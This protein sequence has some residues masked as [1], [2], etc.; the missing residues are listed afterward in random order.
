MAS[1]NPRSTATTSLATCCPRRMP[2]ATPPGSNTIPWGIAPNGFCLAASSKRTVTTPRGTISYS[3]DEAGNLAHLE[4]TNGTKHVYEYDELN[5]LAAAID[6]R[7]DPR[8]DPTV[9]TSTTIYTYDA[10]GTL[11]AVG[12][13]TGANIGFI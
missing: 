10:T 4:T 11:Q 2:T 6:L 5:R 7:L 13:P 12:L 3:Y 1:I 9:N 8:F